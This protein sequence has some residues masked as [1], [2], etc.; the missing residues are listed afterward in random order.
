MSFHHSWYINIVS[1]IWIVSL[2]CWEGVNNKGWTWSSSTLVSKIC[3][4]RYDGDVSIIRTAFI[5]INNVWKLRWWKW[6]WQMGNTVIKHWLELPCGLHSNCT[7]FFFKKLQHL[8]FSPQ[9]RL[10]F[11]NIS[12]IVHSTV[13]YISF[14]S[15]RP[16]ENFRHRFQWIGNTV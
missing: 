14:H 11:C 13:F 16:R 3:M 9:K 2:S 10:P 7:P 8:V 4:P 1:Y 12:F 15:E 5:N 6:R